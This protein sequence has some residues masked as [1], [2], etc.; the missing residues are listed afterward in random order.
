MAGFLIAIISGCL[1]S[2]QGV[3]NTAVTKASSL[4]VTA[5][6]VQITAFVT[7]FAMWIYD[8][9][10]DVLKIFK[11]ESKYTL[12]GGVIGAFIT[13]TV[14][15]S[16]SRLGVAKAELLI[17]ISQVIISYVIQVLGLFGVEKEHV[18]LTKVLALGVA[19]VGSAVF[20]LAGNSSTN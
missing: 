16:I 6:F 2:V 9:R 18:S 3:F 12:L 20:F 15:V 4:W 1:M 14:I 5:M 7:C 13:F 8:G 17:V 19:L 11:V 10:P